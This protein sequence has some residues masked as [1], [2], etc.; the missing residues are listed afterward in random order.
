MIFDDFG[1]DLIHHSKLY[2]YKTLLPNTFIFIYFLFF[3]FFQT[4][5]AARR[6]RAVIPT[7]DNTLNFAHGLHGEWFAHTLQL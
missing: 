3:Y 1:T 7:R 4:S 6:L 5:S 2:G